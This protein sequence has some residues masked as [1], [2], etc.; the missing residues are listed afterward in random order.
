MVPCLKNIFYEVLIA[1]QR[2]YRRQQICR[3]QV[4]PPLTPLFVEMFRTRLRTRYRDLDVFVLSVVGGGGIEVNP[5][6]SARR[7]R[8]DALAGCAV[9]AHRSNTSQCEGET[10]LR[11]NDAIA[12]KFLLAS[13]CCVCA[14][15]DFHALSVL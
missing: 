5:G 8:R 1:R 6:L 12:T 13:H 15:V 7:H 14:S 11:S 2:S 10:V 9:A 3:F 4:F